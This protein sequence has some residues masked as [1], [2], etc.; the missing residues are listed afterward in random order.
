MPLYRPATEK[1]LKLCPG[2][3]KHGS[4]FTTLM[5]QGSFYLPWAEKKFTAAGGKIHKRL[6]DNLASLS[7][8]YDII[9]NCS[10]LGARYLANDNQVVPIRGQVIKVREAFKKNTN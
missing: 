1:E 2:N 5:T 4:F 6:V 8:E 7:T 3:W 10:G 9:V